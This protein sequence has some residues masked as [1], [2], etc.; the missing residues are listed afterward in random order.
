M[1]GSALEVGWLM[2]I[3]SLMQ[4]IFSPFWGQLSDRYGRRKIL[5]GCL[6][7][8]GFTYIWFALARDY[9]SLFF[10]RGLAGFFG[11]SISTAS[12]FISDIT[13]PRSAQKEW[14]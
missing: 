1:G 12:A 14:H 13:P 6:L 5:V 10:A 3:Y 8:E 7:A 2:A 11:A 4:F 9:W